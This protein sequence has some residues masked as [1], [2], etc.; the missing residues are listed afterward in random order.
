MG[1]MAGI[2]LHYITRDKFTSGYI[3]FMSQYMKQQNHYFITTNSSSY[4]SQL[5]NADNVICIDNNVEML[6]DE[7]TKYLLKVCDKFIVSGIFGIHKVLT[8]FNECVLK[9]TYLQF[10]GGDFYDYRR[11]IDKDKLIEKKIIKDLIKKCRGI[12]NL[13]SED[14]KALRQVFLLK[15]QYRHF[16]AP[17][18]SDFF[19]QIRFDEYRKYGDSIVKK[20]QIRIIVG[21]SAT[22]ENCHEEIFDLLK[23]VKGIEVYCPLSYGDEEY[24]DYIIKLGNACLG[25]AFH[26]ITKFMDFDDYLK[27]LSTCDIGIFNNNRQQAMGNISILL[28]LGKKIYLREETAMWSSYKRDGFLFYGIKE[29]KKNL[30]CNKITHLT[31]DEQYYNKCLVEKYVS[32]AYQKQLWETVLEDDITDLPQNGDDVLFNINHLSGKDLCFYLMKILSDRKEL[33]EN[34]IITN[35]IGRFI[36]A[37]F[38]AD[39]KNVML[40][41]QSVTL[42]YTR[43]KQFDEEK[44]IIFGVGKNGKRCYEFLKNCGMRDK[45][46]CFIDNKKSNAGKK[47]YGIRIESP[48]D[49]VYSTNDKVI[50]TSD[51]Y[52]EEMK[53]QL[54]TLNVNKMCLYRDFVKEYYLERMKVCYPAIYSC[55]LRL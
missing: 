14:Y 38:I 43:G 51:I 23:K 42:K 24:K 15:N 31:S 13:I 20:G 39:M 3:N 17:M 29:L 11:V 33:L 22:I 35:D 26:P 47:L 8:S 21:N 4:S 50:I 27:L 49:I 16:V 41:M 25:E 30:M 28:G 53:D 36:V 40:G 48:H 7:R 19:E 44:I 6:L 18:P 55:L 10:W 9:K 5:I 46:F 32:V 37:L 52:Y 12:I 2:I 54:L 34:Y 1:E 45:I